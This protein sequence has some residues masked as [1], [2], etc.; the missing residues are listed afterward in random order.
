MH[1][2]EG[3]PIVA[4]L[5]EDIVSCE[6]IADGGHVDPELMRL[7]FR[8]LGAERT[9]V[10]TDNMHMAGTDT[11]SGKFA[12]ESVEVSGAKAVR[13]DGTIVGSVAT[14][15][16]HFR[17]VIQYLEVDLRKAFRMCSTNPARVAEAARKG[18]LEPGMDADIV[19]LDEGLQVAATVCRGRLAWQRED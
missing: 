1:Q 16:T 17:N 3:G 18:R 19:I 7:A 8:F 11:A 2:R 13:R 10:V 14:M 5:F 9:V 12:G 15:D 4:A 6:L